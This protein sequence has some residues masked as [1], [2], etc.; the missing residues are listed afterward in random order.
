MRAASF[1][2]LKLLNLGIGEVKSAA[3]ESSESPVTTVLLLGQGSEVTAKFGATSELTQP[4]TAW[5]LLD[6][7]NSFVMREETQG[8]SL[9]QF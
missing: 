9:V 7:E 8:A 2:L 4:F 6:T 1:C 3:P 5:L